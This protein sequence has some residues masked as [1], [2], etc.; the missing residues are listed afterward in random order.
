MKKVYIDNLSFETFNNW[1]IFEIK[2]AD[3]PS[4]VTP[5][6]YRFNLIQ[7]FF[8]GKEY[9][10]SNFADFIAEKKISGFKNSTI[11]RMISCGKQIAVYFGL[12]TFQGITFFPEN[13]YSRRDV[14]SWEEMDRLATVQV[15]YKDTR[16]MKASD[17][18]L[19]NYCV[20]RLLSETGCRISE[21]LNLKW[22][23]VDGN[24]LTFEDTKN[25]ENR[26]V[27]IT[28]QLS[29][30]IQDLPR[31][32]DLVFNT[33]SK[34]TF[35]IDLKRRIHILGMTKRTPISAH[36]FR[37]SVITNLAVSGAP[38]NL[39]QAMAGHKNLATTSN[40]IHNQLRDVENMMYQ[41]SALWGY[42][43]SKEMFLK[44]AYE[45]VSRLLTWRATRIKMDED[46]HFYLIKIP[47]NVFV[48][49]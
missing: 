41:Y 37:H 31:H 39:V 35:N 17:Y 44:R 47:K 33:L 14:L 29:A 1:L 34:T 28:D 20:L 38:I 13:K 30:S 2:L 43:L 42:S 48:L 36:L 45:S 27:V 5:R 8:K 11:N 9:T 7:K 15:P 46:R 12:E 10:R 4:A 26:S 32:C 22:I 3:K 18:A 49:P 21:A 16:Y 19:K 40:Y 6:R 25:S 24:I 23:N